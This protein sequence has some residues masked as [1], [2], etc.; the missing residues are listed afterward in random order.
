[1]EAGSSTAVESCGQM[2][3]KVI[4]KLWIMWKKRWISIYN[5]LFLVDNGVDL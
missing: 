2:L 5:T 3:N 1:M 4:N